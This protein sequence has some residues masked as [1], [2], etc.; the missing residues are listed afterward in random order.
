M[1][2]VYIDFFKV[3]LHICLKWLGYLMNISSE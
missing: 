3:M 2:Q 1:E